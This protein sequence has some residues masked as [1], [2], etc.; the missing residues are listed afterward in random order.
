[1]KAAVTF[2]TR[3]V[4]AGLL[5]IVP[6]YLAVLLLLKG[7]KAV[8]G[9]VGPIAQLLPS[10]IPA[11]PILSLLLVLLTCFILGVAVRSRVG[12]AARDR[13]ETSLIERIPG[14]A[15][16][17]SL[18]QQVAGNTAE[19]VWKPALVE[20]GDGFVP[21]F[22]IEE[23]GDGRCT[24][25]I[26]SVPT[27]LAGAILVLER[28][29]V[30]PVN[31]PVTSVESSIGRRE[32]AAKNVPQLCIADEGHQWRRRICGVIGKTRRDSHSGMR[33]SHR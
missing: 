22:M 32:I 20:T 13:M 2:V 12:R 23:F 18:T 17:R 3:A 14:Y 21:G 11:E 28:N 4:I 33:V 16:I 27:P 1:M 31:V 30:H 26:P 7:L 10:T 24:V 6:I 29:R 15:L 25:F 19:S 9:L 8:V 5:I